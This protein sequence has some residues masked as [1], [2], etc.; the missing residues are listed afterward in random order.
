MCERP[1]PARVR[2][3]STRW[4]VV[5]LMLCALHAAEAVASGVNAADPPQRGKGISMPRQ[6]DAQGCSITAQSR[7]FCTTHYKRVQARQRELEAAGALSDRA[8]Q[9]A[10]AEA[11][12]PRRP[13]APDAQAVA[14][15]AALGIPADSDEP[16]GELILKVADIRKE[17]REVPGLRT[18][19]AAQKAR[20]EKAEAAPRTPSEEC[21]S[22]LEESTEL[23]TLLG[24]DGELVDAVRGIIAQRDTFQ[25]QRTRYAQLAEA[26]GG[27]L[28]GLLGGL[29]L[30]VEEAGIPGWSMEGGAAPAVAW[31]QAQGVA[32][33][34]EMR[35]E[36]RTLSQTANDWRA[37]YEA[38]EK[39]HADTFNMLGEAHAQA[40]TLGRELADLRAGAPIAAA[41]SASL[42]DGWTIETWSSGGDQHFRLRTKEGRSV[43]GGDTL[44]GAIRDT[45]VRL[46]TELSRASER[47]AQDLREVRE[48]QDEAIACIAERLAPPVRALTWRVEWVGSV[49][50]L[51]VGHVSISIAEVVDDGS[52]VW[53]GQWAGMNEHRIPASSPR[54]AVAIITALLGLRGFTVPPPVSA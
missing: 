29:E 26:R 10:I 21:A 20:A 35:S 37:A 36:I 47:A 23:C 49:L 45:I 54:E 24:V 43:G 1:S 4:P 18:S 40:E 22:L 6:C 31:G 3:Y 34:A 28:A 2:V 52:E 48:R 8:W 9:E 38:E 33:L 27:A 30:S 44:P 12:E 50:T 7:G 11:K 42:P 17:A 16:F 19:L 41:L 25:E 15:R 5:E 51:Y 39:R 14:L 53:L 32:K 13:L 46:Q